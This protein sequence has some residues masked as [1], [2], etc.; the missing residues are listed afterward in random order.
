MAQQELFEVWVHEV[1]DMHWAMLGAFTDFDIANAL[2]QSRKTR[3]RLIRAAFDDGKQ[4]ASDVI[5]EIG[6]TRTGY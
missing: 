2:T 4:I 5:A 1:E 3:V 6:D